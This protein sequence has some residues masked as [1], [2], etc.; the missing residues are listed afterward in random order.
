M[1]EI[2]LSQALK[3]R[4]KGSVQ[5]LLG[6][7]GACLAMTLGLVGCQDAFEAP[8]VQSSGPKAPSAAA[9]STTDDSAASGPVVVPV[10]TTD[11]GEIA[12]IPVDMPARARKRM[13]IYQLNAAVRKVTG[14]IGWVEVRNG[15]EV[16]LF[17]ELAATLGRPDYILTTHE[18]LS[19]SVLLEKFVGDAARSVCTTLA[20]NERALSQDERVLMPYV[21][22][23]DT[24]EKDPAAIEENMRYL[25]MRY[26]GTYIEPGSSELNLWTWLFDA[27]TMATADPVKGWRAVCVALISHPDFY[28]N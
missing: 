17:E 14:G 8:A 28:S 11:E 5:H 26:H 10:Q 23:T 27:T 4:V 24:W 9:P 22:L 21:S 19:P 16:D 2:I 20:E 15:K 1:N 3:K 18:D 13:N 12:L 7:A 25:L 6:V